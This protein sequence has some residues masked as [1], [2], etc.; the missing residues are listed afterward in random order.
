VVIQNNYLDA[1]AGIYLLSYGGDHTTA[2]TIKITGNRARNIDGRRSNGIGG[3]LSFNIR[4]SKT[5]GH[6][7]VGY[8][9]VQFAQL[10]KVNSVP[11]IDISWN[12]VINK[13]GA[14][15]VE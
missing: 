8:D 10:D 3:Y 11:G 9:E 2:N 14:S 5:D 12:E 15:R 13:A 1:T 6:T 4:T 7:D